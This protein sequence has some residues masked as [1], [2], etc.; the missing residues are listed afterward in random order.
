MAKWRLVINQNRENLN[1]DSCEANC[2]TVFS[3]SFNTSSMA[4][5]ADNQPN[6]ARS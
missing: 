6:E 3:V 5:K 4:E 2:E 1:Y